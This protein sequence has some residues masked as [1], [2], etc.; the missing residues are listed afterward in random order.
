M[1]ETPLIGG[2][3]AGKVMA[4]WRH[5]GSGGRVLLVVSSYQ[6]R[7]TQL[8]AQ[9]RPMVRELRQAGCTGGQRDRLLERLIPLYDAL[10]TLHDE[11]DLS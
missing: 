10:F 2:F 6:L 1:A 11:L 5:H 9:I 4:T 7:I 3:P 8:Q